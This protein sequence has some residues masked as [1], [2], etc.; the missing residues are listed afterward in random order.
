MFKKYITHSG[1][2]LL[3]YSIIYYTYRK[4]Y[5]C[6]AVAHKRNSS[7]KAINFFNYYLT[8]PPVHQYN[9]IMYFITALNIE[10]K[11]FL[12]LIFFSIPRNLR[13]PSPFK[14][15]LQMFSQIFTYFR[16]CLLSCILYRYQF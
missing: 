10:L 9:N 16:S 1:I 15:S 13:K 7:R 3:P 5:T 4:T 6:C 11:H 8:T 12:L 2:L 14:T